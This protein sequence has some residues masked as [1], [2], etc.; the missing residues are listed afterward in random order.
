M[1]AITIALTAEVVSA[2]TMVANRLARVIA[3]Q[4]IAPAVAVS[5]A[6]VIRTTVTAGCATCTATMATAVASTIPTAVTTTT[7]TT[8]FRIGGI[9]GRQFSREQWRGCKHQGA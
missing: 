6:R 7:T 8:V 2:F 5:A 4:A 3:G 9:H 1:T